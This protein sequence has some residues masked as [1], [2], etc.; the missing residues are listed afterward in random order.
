MPLRVERV[1]RKRLC[2]FVLQ[3]RRKR[4]GRTPV[5]GPHSADIAFQRLAPDLR[6]GSLEQ[7]RLGAGG[8]QPKWTVRRPKSSY[9]Q[10][11][12]RIHSLRNIARLIRSPLGGDDW[13]W[14]MLD[15]DFESSEDVMLPCGLREN[16][17]VSMM[18][19]ELTPED[20][21]KLCKLD[22]AVPTRNTLEEG[23]VDNLPRLCD[24]EK[25]D[26]EC[27][28]C[29]SNLSSGDVAK[30]PC[31]HSFHAPC[32]KKWLTRFGSHLIAPVC[33][34]SIALVRPV[35]FQVL[36]TRVNLIPLLVPHMRQCKNTCPICYVVIGKP[37]AEAA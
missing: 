13:D 31:G 26:G 23:H 1:S 6:I 9:L 19:R 29:L 35:G 24:W 15:S 14:E 16:E 21:E 17:A 22:E 20:Y 18:H 37:D 11:L 27:G 8:R 2:L 5:L 34:R 32:I 7:R 12:Y 36:Y 28:V 30:L 25:S 10:R 4:S 33:I 3:A